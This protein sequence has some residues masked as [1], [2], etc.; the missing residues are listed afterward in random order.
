MIYLTSQDCISWR[1]LDKNCFWI[2]AWYFRGYSGRYFF[3]HFQGFLEYFTCIFGVNL[4]IWYQATFY[5][6]IGWKTGAWQSKNRAKLTLKRKTGT[7]IF[8]LVPLS[9]G[10]FN[11]SIVNTISKL[12][13]SQRNGTNHPKKA[14][15]PKCP[16]KQ[17][18][19]YK[20]WQLRHTALATLSTS[21]Q[22]RKLSDRQPFVHQTTVFQHCPSSQ[23]SQHPPGHPW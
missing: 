18:C 23:P 11:L 14:V 3:S 22:Y 8:L 1:Q 16:F 4:L 12:Q 7:C 2:F 6:N 21:D 15:L 17:A 10:L 19:P 20:N 9:F 5:Q 13:I